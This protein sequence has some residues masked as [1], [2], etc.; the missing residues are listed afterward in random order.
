MPAGWLK[1]KHHSR[2]RRIVGLF[3]NDT[4]AMKEWMFWV[5]AC[6]D[7]HTNC[8]NVV[9]S[10]KRQGYLC[11]MKAVGIS[12]RKTSYCQYCSEKNKEE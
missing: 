11:A 12:E 2:R 4:F 3:L 6:S 5:F 10:S 8:V 9:N 1:L 7:V